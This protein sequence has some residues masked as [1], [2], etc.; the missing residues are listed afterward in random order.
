MPNGT[1]FVEDT[2]AYATFQFRQA[3]KRLVKSSFSHSVIPKDLVQKRNS[4]QLLN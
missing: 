4:S 1:A 2:E 3:F